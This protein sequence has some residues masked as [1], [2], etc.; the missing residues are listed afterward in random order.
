MFLLVS[1]VFLGSSVF[2]RGI[3]VVDFFRERSI[4][5]VV[6]LVCVCGGGAVVGCVGCFGVFMGSGSYGMWNV[7]NFLFREGRLGY[8]YKV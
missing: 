5:R 2:F 3:W 6:F 1:F 8:L 4:V 7:V